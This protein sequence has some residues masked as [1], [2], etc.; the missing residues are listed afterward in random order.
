MAVDAPSPGASAQAPA[1][2]PKSRHI[3]RRTL[4][5]RPGA[6]GTREILT[7]YGSRISRET[8]IYA[9][10][11]GMVFPLGIIQ[12]AVLTHFLAPS[13]FGEL[14]VLL[15][16]A[17]MVTLIMN[18]GSLQGTFMWTFG[19]SGDGDGADI[20][21]EFDDDDAAGA[22]D[23]RVAL[24]TGLFMTIGI[25]I[26]LAVPL[27]VWSS[28][29]AGLLIGDS[30]RGNLVV[31]ATLSAVAGAL[32]RLTVTALRHERRPVLYSIAQMLRPISVVAIAV[33]LVA[34]GEGIRGALI[35][36]ALGSAIG[37]LFCFGVD[38]RSYGFAFDREDAVKMLR[39]GGVF[40]FIVAGLWLVHDADIYLVSWFSSPT[41]TGL[42][43]L[44]SRLATLP[45]YLVAAFMFA[46][47]S[48]ERSML[49]HA[50]YERRGHH[51]TK[52][53]LL[54][55]YMFCALWLV[56]GL[57]IGADLIVQI[58]PPS[59]AGAARYIPLLGVAYLCY[60]AYV[61]IMRS[62][63]VPR[64]RLVYAGSALTAGGVFVGLAILLIPLIG[65]YGAPIGEIVGL[66]SVALFL[67]WLMR[68]VDMPLGVQTGPI[69]KGVLAC[70]LCWAVGTRLSHV[71]GAARW[72]VEALT[73]LL[74]PVLL[75]VTGAIPRNH[76]GPLA[77]ISQNTLP[78]T[79]RSPL[80]DR[81]PG[82]APR[83]R[84]VLEAIA[85][86]R[87]PAGSVAA[88]HGLTVDEVG[89]RLTRALRQ[90]TGTGEHGDDDVLLGQYLLYDGGPGDRD[91]WA[92]SL[93]LEGIDALDI[94]ELDTAFLSLRRTPRRAW[95][96][97]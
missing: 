19:S 94:H 97:L 50:T 39:L 29:I 17:A 1:R 18:T 8:A 7:Q 54:T 37:V 74:Y 53:T 26:A 67:L 28:Q 24:S 62:A 92:R 44:A 88:E 78:R 47:S 60:G 87:R 65:P 45:S 10:G 38:H 76:L 81:V 11:M 86:D 43:R 59:Y 5:I 2:S 4:E 40:V 89:V 33:P 71:L 68:R 90:L 34:T 42:Y 57:S 51:Q 63:Q 36:T 66:G 64:R 48:L 15:T 95:R 9:L 85:R 14:G 20:S 91:S 77:K 25:C 30:N 61:V 22:A 70:G 55:Y 93:T 41:D 52:S 31:W 6:R 75:I 82:I 3:N 96:R 84:H 27:I 83:R 49:F 69:L 79:R 16:F 13:V 58:A 21:V 72:P 80:L 73:L 56:L 35:G 46:Q 32:W 12:V 23:K